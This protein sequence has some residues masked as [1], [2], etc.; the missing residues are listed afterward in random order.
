MTWPRNWS[1]AWRASVRSCEHLPRVA[2]EEL[3]GARRHG[4]PAQSV[5]QPGP[6][7][8]LQEPHVLAHGGLREAEGRSGPG[9][10]AKLVHPGEDLEL[11]E[12]HEGAGCPRQRSA[13]RVR[14]SSRKRSTFRS[15][16]VL[17][18]ADQ[19]RQA[20]ELHGALVALGREAAQRALDQ[21][22]VLADERALDP[23]H[24]RVAE[25]I[26]RGA[27][28]T[29]HRD[30]Q[31]EHPLE[32]R[33]ERELPLHAE[34]PQERRMELVAH[35]GLAQ[36][37]LDRRADLRPEVQPRHLVLVL[38]GHQLEEV[39]RHRLGEPRL[40]R[41]GRP[42]RLGDRPDEVDVAARVGRVLVGDQLGDADLE[43]PPQ[44]A[45][46]AHGVDQRPRLGPE[47]APRG[48]GARP[49]PL[50]RLGPCRIGDQEP[51]HAERLGVHLDRDAVER[52]RLL[53][54]RGAHGDRARL[55]GRAQ[56][57]HVGGHVVAEERLR[58]GRARRRRRSR[59]CGS[60][61]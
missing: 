5:E 36:L 12:I 15:L 37:R 24:L 56:Q 55:V 28:Q 7:L 44:L 40:A 20:R 10:A 41:H 8:L 45:A 33:A 53:D 42:L 47:L 31:P 29:P 1:S 6:Q 2:V 39:A 34:R 4:L 23:A 14:A 16:I 26:E 54:R 9:E 51:A 58:P 49:A 43:Q 52:D 18:A 32:P 48:H 27:A 30:Q 60:R 46:G 11:A 25:R 57:D 61:G 13:P 38:V 22:A 50:D 35:L 19:V 21:A 17:V 3:P 59:P